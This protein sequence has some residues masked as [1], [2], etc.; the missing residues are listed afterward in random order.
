MKLDD[1]REE[2]L[3]E[4]IRLYESHCGYGREFSDAMFQEPETVL[5]NLRKES[6]EEYRIGSKWDMHSKIYF[7]TDF[8][9]NL[10]IRFNPNFDPQDRKSERHSIAEKAGEE[11]VK[12]AMQYLNSQ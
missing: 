9:G 6:N 12:T 3:I 10:I 7:K 11:F 1:L 4:V 8:E 5:R 2:H